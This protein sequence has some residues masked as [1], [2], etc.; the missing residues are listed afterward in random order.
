MIR[1]T[2][3]AVLTA[4]SAILCVSSQCPPQGKS[5]MSDSSQ[6][7][8]QTPGSP[9]ANAGALAGST[10]LRAGSETVASSATAAMDT[11]DTLL[12]QGVSPSDAYA[13]VLAQLQA[14]PQVV[15]AGMA[16]DGD[17]VWAEFNGG[18]T[19]WFASFDQTTPVPELQDEQNPPAVAK[20]IQ[21]AKALPRAPAQGA[22]TDTYRMPANNKAL[23]ANS[24][25]FYHGNEHYNDN[26]ATLEKMLRARGYVAQPHLLTLDDFDNFSAYSVIFLDAHASWRPLQYA[27]SICSDA[28]RTH[29][30]LTTTEATQ[31]LIV[32]HAGDIG[33]GGL[34][35]WNCRIRREDGTVQRTQCFGVTPTYVRRHSTG[36]FPGNTFFVLNGCRGYALD[37]SSPWRDLLF[38]KGN[39]GLFAGWARKPYFGNA[40]RAMLYW[41]QLMTGSNEE[42]VIDDVRI[43]KKSTPPQAN[44]TPA[45][46]AFEQI[47]QRGLGVDPKS[48]AQLVYSDQPGET[49]KMILMPHI[50][51]WRGCNDV[52]DNSVGRDVDIYA[53][54]G[55]LQVLIGETV[56]TSQL[57]RPNLIRITE[58]TAAYGQMVLKQADRTSIPR[59]LHRWRP[60]LEI[61][62][63]GGP[64]RPGLTYTATVVGHA[65]GMV[66]NGRTASWLDPPPAE[67]G[68]LIWDNPHCTAGWN[69]SGEGDYAEGVHMKYS[70]SGLRV[71]EKDE[72][73][74][75]YYNSGGGSA[76]L[77]FGVHLPATMEITA[78]NISISSIFLGVAAVVNDA[79]VSEDWTVLSGAAQ[80]MDTA[81]GA[82]NVKW[83]SFAC[84][85]PFDPVSEP[86]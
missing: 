79:Q 61:T 12:Q 76:S 22:S 34:D 10:H 25:A 51:L 57:L 7:D 47:D 29:V 66:A 70:G 73:G 45:P 27:V 49:R 72:V 75:L 68:A 67:F 23:L 71:F 21:A 80:A 5:G 82:V 24:Y 65:R 26:T 20:A 19:H 84:E 36:P 48:K 44:F 28:M 6:S 63:T 62:G 43:I 74:T 8:S 1:S 9:Q 42:L 31:D 56:M 64:A 78:G 2:S 11:L 50:A 17:A 35:L 46:D 58:P 60:V 59:I 40:G 83:N 77:T 52:G 4:F 39:G 69:V 53:D 81:G 85:P 15:A 41:F 55:D 38:Q 13:Q 54:A 16:E 30:I 3:A 18:E 32:Q 86:R 37:M 14:D 33:C